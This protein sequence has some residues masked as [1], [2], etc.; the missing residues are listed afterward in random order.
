VSPFGAEFLTR[1]GQVPT[2]TEQTFGGCTVAINFACGPYQIAGLDPEQ[3]R[4]VTARYQTLCTNPDSGAGIEAT[5]HPLPA[6]EFRAIDTRGWEYRLDLRY[7]PNR[8]RFAGW[9]LVGEMSVPATRAR[10]FVATDAGARFVGMVENFFRLAVA[11]RLLAAGGALLHSA[12]IARAGG[13]YVFFGQSGAGKTTLCTLSCGDDRTILSDEL[14]ALWPAPGGAVVEQLPFAGD[15]GAAP[16][17]RGRFPARGLFRLV[18]APRTAMV[19]M[20]PAQ[21][22][23]SL[24]AASPFVN[25]DPYRIPAAVDNLSRLAR[26]IAPQSL[27]FSLTESVWD[28]LSEVEL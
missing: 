2:Q 9:G 6:D 16:A 23:G 21:A 3:H 15:Y 28:L 24:V 1:P 26:A 25:G 22:V 17:V 27:E 4:L 20:S 11:Y 19:S 18:Q 14:N 10:V 7:E 5:F 8:V 12:G 13:A